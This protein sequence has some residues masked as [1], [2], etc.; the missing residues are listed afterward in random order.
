M[1]RAETNRQVVNLNKYSYVFN[2]VD[3]N[4]QTSRLKV[5]LKDLKNENLG[6]NNDF[7]NLKK[8]SIKPP[9]KTVNT[10]HKNLNSF[11]ISQDR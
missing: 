6:D 9:N 11:R 2:D 7:S 4:I 1:R 8:K 3:T 10:I 5:T